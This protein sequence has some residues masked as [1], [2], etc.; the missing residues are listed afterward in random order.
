MFSLQRDSAIATTDSRARALISAELGKLHFSLLHA[1]VERVGAR[2]RQQRRRPLPKELRGGLRPP[3]AT[4]ENGRSSRD[5]F[6]TE[7]RGLEEGGIPTLPPP[8]PGELKQDY[9]T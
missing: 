1:V 9:I 6:R 3:M 8:P 4:F 5:D 7:K 2:S